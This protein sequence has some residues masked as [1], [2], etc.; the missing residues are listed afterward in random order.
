MLHMNDD[1]HFLKVNMGDDDDPVS[2]L[3]W[4]FTRRSLNDLLAERKLRRSL[5]LVRAISV[6]KVEETDAQLA[7]P[8]H[9]I[10]AGV[11]STRMFVSGFDSDGLTRTTQQHI[12]VLKK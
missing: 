1:F 11:K 9:Q 3:K 6:L 4:T 2:Y 12:E 5:H 7:N 10:A 8:S